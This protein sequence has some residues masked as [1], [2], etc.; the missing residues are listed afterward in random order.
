MSHG[1]FE[2]GSCLFICMEYL[3]LG[4]LRA[5]LAKRDQPWVPEAEARQII[6]QVLEALRFMHTE[7]FT[8]ADVKPANILIR[9][10]PP[11]G[12]WWVK[13]SDLG[14]S[15][16]IEATR[17]S[18]GIQGT[19]GF[20]APE[21]YGFQKDKTKT[22]EGI[23]GRRTELWYSA[24]IWATGETAFRLITGK[25]TFQYPDMLEMYAQGMREFPI[26]VLTQSPCRPSP[27][28][29]DF[30]TGL[31]VADPSERPTAS[32]A[33]DHPWIMEELRRGRLTRTED[34]INFESR[35][36]CR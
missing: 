20:I 3:P 25:A 19:E 15:R 8:H 14:L 22:S 23:R 6:S 32:M 26:S 36:L 34:A 16:R 33:C 10:K 29:M 21:I 11:S 13:L 27:D 18:V 30:I 24:D 17:G 7:R 28:L 4:D 2:S 12:D 31:M 1:W 5:Y 9:S 35:Y